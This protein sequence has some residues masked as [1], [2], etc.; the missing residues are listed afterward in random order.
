MIKAGKLRTLSEAAVNR[1]SRAAALDHYVDLYDSAPVG[2]CTLTGEVISNANL[3]IAGLLGLDRKALIGQPLPRF[4]HGQDQEACSLFLQRVFELDERQECELRMLAMDGTVFWAHLTAT[5]AR[6]GPDPGQGSGCRLTVLDI[7]GRKR[8]EEHKAMLEGLRQQ[9]QK[10]KTLGDFAGGMAHDFNNLLAT[11][12]GNANLTSLMIEPDSKVLSFLQAI[13]TAAMKAAKLTRKMLAFSGQGPFLQAEVDLNLVL[14]ESLQLISEVIPPPGGRPPGAGR[15]APFRPGRL[16]PY[17]RGH[18]RS[19]HQRRG[20][21]GPRPGRAA[22][23]P[24]PGRAAR[25]GRH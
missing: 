9:A 3:A 18:G 14:K 25:P 5:T 23:G 21:D 11:I 22:A 24:D 15:P 8:A 2:Y 4:V 17:L 1:H 10:F 6:P 12:V 16:R 20:G 13:E 7:T 19:A